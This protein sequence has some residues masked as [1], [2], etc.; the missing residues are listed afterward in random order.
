MGDKKSVS[1][2]LIG[3]SLVHIAPHV[4]MH[5]SY[6]S[7][8]VLL[9][10]FH[11]TVRSIDTDC[12]RSKLGEGWVKRFLNHNLYITLATEVLVGNPL[13]TNLLRQFVPA[14]RWR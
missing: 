2:V 5:S 1:A 11:H 10:F 3:Y 9:H 13:F 4:P 7:L 14:P 8:S 6:I 12:T